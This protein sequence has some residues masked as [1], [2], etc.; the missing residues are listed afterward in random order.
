MT[1]AATDIVDMS[2]GMI[3][4]ENYSSAR[5]SLITPKRSASALPLGRF[6]DL[7]TVLQAAGV[8]KLVIAIAPKGITAR[9]AHEVTVRYV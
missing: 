5:A 3:Y 2:A 8:R 4:F 1:A 9:L 7:P 6:G